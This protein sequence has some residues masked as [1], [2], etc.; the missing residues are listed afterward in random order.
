MEREGRARERVSW[1]Y[2]FFWKPT[3][4]RG[5]SI[6]AQNRALLGGGGGDCGAAKPVNLYLI[7]QLLDFRPKRVF[8]LWCGRRR[9]VKV[10]LLLGCIPDVGEQVGE[11]LRGLKVDLSV[12]GVHCLLHGRGAG[13]SEMVFEPL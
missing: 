2:W 10:E 4:T 11:I 6:G 9:D 13:E 7:Y 3:L 5:Q 12:V 1:M 8:A